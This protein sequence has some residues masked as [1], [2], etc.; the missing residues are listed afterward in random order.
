MTRVVIVGAGG[1]GGELA[2]VARACAGAG[3]PIE[4]LG[5]VDDSPALRGKVLRDLPVLGG[6]EWLLAHRDVEAVVGIGSPTVRRR[7]VEELDRAGVRCRGLVHPRAELT[8]YVR[9]GVGVV[10]TAGCVLTN[11]IELGD[12]VH[13]NRRTTVGHDCRIGAF[14]HLAPGVSLSG[15]VTVGEG[16]DIGTNACVIQ[17]LSIGAWTIVG[18][19]AAVIHDLPSDCTAVGVPA[20]VIHSRIRAAQA[21]S[22]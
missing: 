21:S 2:D 11:D 9:M 6:M 19:G 13:L 17:N 16:C 8:P 4:V 22:S 10:I 20:R 7:V 5:Y 1:H 14:T 12:H 15:N 3:Q 18:A